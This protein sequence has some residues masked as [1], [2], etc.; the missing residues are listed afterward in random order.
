MHI[1][2]GDLS[3]IVPAILIGTYIQSSHVRLTQSPVQFV[4][5]V[6]EITLPIPAVLRIVALTD[7][8]HLERVKGISGSCRSRRTGVMETLHSDG[9]DLRV[10]DDIFPT[11]RIIIVYG[12]A[13]TLD[14]V[15]A[16]RRDEFRKIYRLAKALEIARDLLRRIPYLDVS[17]GVRIGDPDDDD[18]AHTAD[19]REIIARLIGVMERTA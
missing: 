4:G 13:P 11:L 10:P 14:E 2:M 17:L 8:P 1:T 7:Y 12:P 9:D 16:S 5:E 6:R 15:L 18:R 3:N 19:D